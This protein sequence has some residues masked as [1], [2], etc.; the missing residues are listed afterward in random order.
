MLLLTSQRRYFLAERRAIFLPSD[1]TSQ[2]YWYFSSECVWQAPEWLTRLRC[3]SRQSEYRNL[4][5]FFCN[6]LGVRN[7]KWHDAIGELKDM[8]SNQV[9]DKA[10]AQSIYRHL[11][12]DFAH[13]SVFEAL[14]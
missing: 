14:L 1:L 9:Q 3:L 10:K 12:R 5:D 2:P 4:R 11:H 7:Y 13:E 6:I 8:R